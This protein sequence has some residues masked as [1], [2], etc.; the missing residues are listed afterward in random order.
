MLSKFFEK[1][2]KN[3]L[4]GQEYFGKIPG[5]MRF[6]D[7]ETHQKTYVS[8]L[9][10][11][12]NYFGD[13]TEQNRF[14]GKKTLCHQQLVNKVGSDAINMLVNTSIKY[15]SDDTDLTI[16]G[17]WQL[18]LWRIMTVYPLGFAFENYAVRDNNPIGPTWNPL[19]TSLPSYCPSGNIKI[20]PSKRTL[21]GGNISQG[22]FTKLFPEYFSGD[23]SPMVMFAIL[24]VFSI[25]PNVDNPL[26]VALRNA[27]RKQ[28]INDYF[29]MPYFWDEFIY[30]LLANSSD[31]LLAFEQAKGNK[32]KLFDPMSVQPNQT[33]TVRRVGQESFSEN[34]SEFRQ[35]ST[36][37]NRD[38]QETDLRG[39]DVDKL[40]IELGGI[41]TNALLDK[42][43]FMNSRGAQMHFIEDS[44]YFVFPIALHNLAKTYNEIKQRDILTGEQLVRLLVSQNIIRIMNAEIILDGR[45]NQSI[46]LAEINKQDHSKFVP[47]MLK[48]ENNKT[49]NI[50][51]SIS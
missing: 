19:I 4:K 39:I 7:E 44:Y 28:V 9:L 24:D 17:T 50:I 21:S 22:I 6:V 33:V 42:E 51:S 27:I 1:K 3:K 46:Q 47:M 13:L 14:A 29:P 41:V 11:V 48:P 20:E 16:D 34:E 49:I 2:G 30:H 18:L 26:F 31:A 38:S 43:Y 5:S 45:E 36:Q 32:N 23:F 12:C 8:D 25:K 15:W 37:D 40:V 35:V 10:L